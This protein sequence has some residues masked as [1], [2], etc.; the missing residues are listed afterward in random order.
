M[1]NKKA[2]MLGEYTLKII[3]AVIC[4]L[5]LFYLL[6]NL[7][8]N[9]KNER[10]LKMA[11][12][13]LNEISEKMNEAKEKGSS[14]LTLLGPEW[15]FFSFRQNMDKPASCGSECICIC[16][17]YANW[18]GGN[19]ED[20][21]A[22]GICKEIDGEVDFSGSKNYVKAFGDFII[23]YENNKFTISENE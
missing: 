4:L 6:F 11:E 10:N 23:K 14:E 22:R 12:S 21:N 1:K 20:C 16:D 3:I 9:S 7:Y 18:L 15:N 13:N 17:S 19:V 5:L 8:S 2:F